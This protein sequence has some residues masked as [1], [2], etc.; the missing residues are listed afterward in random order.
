VSGQ[1]EGNVTTVIFEHAAGHRHW[2]NGGRPTVVLTPEELA[3]RK[4]KFQAVRS[5]NE[6][7]EKRAFRPA[8]AGRTRGAK[9]KARTAN[10]KRLVVA[11]LKSAQSSR[12]LLHNAR[13]FAR[14]TS[15]NRGIESRER[16]P[17]G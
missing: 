17:I 8:D 14:E 1:G 9:T 6:Q 15:I 2:T 4:A 12:A 3:A 5:K 10:R 7:R 13:V 11:C 16:R